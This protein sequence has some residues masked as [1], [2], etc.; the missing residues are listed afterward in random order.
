MEET[1]NQKTS[2]QEQAFLW[3]LFSIVQIL[4]EQLI[5]S[6]IYEYEMTNCKAASLQCVSMLSWVGAQ[7]PEPVLTQNWKRGL[8]W[9]TRICQELN[10][11]LNLGTPGS[12]P[13]QG[14]GYRLRVSEGY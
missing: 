2:S 4:W 14:T 5:F 6:P 11:P 7:Q 1:Q 3:D 8:V 12:T 9:S 10:S 13:V